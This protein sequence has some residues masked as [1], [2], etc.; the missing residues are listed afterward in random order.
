VSAVV[1]VTVDGTRSP[2]GTGRINAIA[3]GVLKAEKVRD[4]MVSITLVSPA[5]IA[6]IN[7]R[8]LSHSGATDVISFALGATPGGA[9]NAVVGDIYIAPDVARENAR[10]FGNGIRE[11]IARLV[12]HGTLHVLGHD[13]PEGDARTASPMWR[14][15]EQLLAKLAR[16][17]R[18]ASAR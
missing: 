7:R 10:R 17:A 13:H 11:E 18:P 15:Q 12:V 4:A 2:L 16:N 1:D 3:L 14:R 9:R 8:H 5:T 6:Q